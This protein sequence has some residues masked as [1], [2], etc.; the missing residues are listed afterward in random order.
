MTSFAEHA[1]IIRL[2]ADILSTIHSLNHHSAIKDGTK[3]Y[4]YSFK[5]GTITLVVGGLDSCWHGGSSYVFPIADDDPATMRPENSIF[6]EAARTVL[7]HRSEFEAR[8]HEA[9]CISVFYDDDWA[10]HAT[11][12]ETI[13]GRAKR[14]L[15]NAS[16]RL[17]AF[18]DEMIHWTLTPGAFP[19]YMASLSEVQML[20]AAAR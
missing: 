4:H 7:D 20:P 6:I 8:L 11:F 12:E 1:A 16:S 5:D 2:S 14:D 3:T 17:D 13:R 9:L 15:G 18:W 10:D 19:D